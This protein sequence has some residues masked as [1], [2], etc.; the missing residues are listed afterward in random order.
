M[1]KKKKKH[2]KKS[3]K[4]QVKKEKKPF[5]VGIDN[6]VF[7]RRSIL[8]SSKGIIDC[9]KKSEGLVD[10]R[11]RKQNYLVEFKKI[12]DELLVLNRKLRSHLPKMHLREKEVPLRAKIQPKPIASPKIH[13][14]LDLLEEELSKV[15]AKLDAL[16]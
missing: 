16:E 3:K 4:V 7:I 8:L 6:P 5:F 9:L 14:H 10:L 13:S 2:K 12:I 11:L 1:K 15:E